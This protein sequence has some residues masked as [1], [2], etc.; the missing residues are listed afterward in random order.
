MSEFLKMDIFF[1]VSTAAV[2]ILTILLSIALIYVLRILRTVERI[3]REASEE[4]TRIRADIQELRSGIRI[5][6]LKWKSIAR[7]FGRY[8][9]DRS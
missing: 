7:M 6:G 8:F 2:V 1:A 4:A 3:S 9:A 5:E